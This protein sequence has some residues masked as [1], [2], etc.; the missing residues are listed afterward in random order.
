MTHILLVT[1]SIYVSIREQLGAVPMFDPFHY[2]TL[3]LLITEVK[4]YIEFFLLHSVDVSKG[5]F[6]EGNEMTRNLGVEDIRDI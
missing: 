6:L 5:L 4:P 1:T 3:I 2:L